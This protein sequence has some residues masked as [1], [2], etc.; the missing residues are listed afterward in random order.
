MVYIV[1]LSDIRNKG[2]YYRMPFGFS[3]VHAGA[4]VLDSQMIYGHVAT[5]FVLWC[6]VQY[7][8][9]QSLTTVLP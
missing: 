4:C 6:P 5:S 3:S 8:A 2:G 1:E 9:Q 7:M